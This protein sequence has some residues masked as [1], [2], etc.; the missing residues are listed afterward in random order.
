MTPDP[1]FSVC[2]HIRKAE[3]TIG[4]RDFSIRRFALGQVFQKWRYRSP[5]CTYKGGENTADIVTGYCH[6]W[7]IFVSDQNVE[8]KLLTK[9]AYFF[10]CACSPL[11]YTYRIRCMVYHAFLHNQE[12]RSTTIASLPLFDGSWRSQN[13]AVRETVV[14]L[15]LPT[16]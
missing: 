7:R 9:H 11:L 13:T 3:S 5:T 15:F 6:S 8:F 4:M 2:V 1:A 12:F 14:F 16:P 10:L